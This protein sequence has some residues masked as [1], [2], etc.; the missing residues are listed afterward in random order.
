MDDQTKKE[1]AALLGMSED[2]LNRHL[3]RPSGPKTFPEK[4]QIVR[5]WSKIRRNLPMYGYLPISLREQKR[6]VFR[7]ESRREAI[8]HLS[9]LAFRYKTHDFRHYLIEDGLVVAE[10]K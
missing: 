10:E 7:S 5:I 8:S 4:Y 3:D 1:L 6:V 9:R 2:E